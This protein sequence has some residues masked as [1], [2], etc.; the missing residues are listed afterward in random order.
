MML[1][2]SVST[3]YPQP[4]ARELRRSAN[5]GQR[6]QVGRGRPG[7]PASHCTKAIRGGVNARWYNAASMG[8]IS[9]SQILFFVILAGMYLY[10]QNPRLFTNPALLGPFVSGMVA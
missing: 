1:E 5:Q 7:I 2:R 10:T 3:R 4:D 6:P 8:R 9:T